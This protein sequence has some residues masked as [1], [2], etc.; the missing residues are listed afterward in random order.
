MPPNPSLNVERQRRLKDLAAKTSALTQRVE[1]ISKTFEGEKKRRSVCLDEVLETL[2]PFA[3]GRAFVANIVTGRAVKHTSHEYELSTL[4]P[5]TVGNLVEEHHS[6]GELHEIGSR[7]PEQCIVSTLLP[8]TVG[9]VIE[10]LHQLGK[11]SAFATSKAERSDVAVLL[12]VTVGTVIEEHHQLGRS[13][14]FATWKTEQSNVAMLLPVTVGTVIEEHHQLGKS[15]AYATSKTEQSTVA[16]LLPVTIGTV[17][18]EH[19]VL[20]EPREIGFD[21]VQQDDVSMLLP[22]TVCSVIEEHCRL[23]EPISLDRSEGSEALVLPPIAVGNLTQRNCPLFDEPSTVHIY[24]E[25]QTSVFPPFVQRTLIEHRLSPLRAEQVKIASEEC[26]ASMIF[27]VSCGIS[28]EKEGALR[29]SEHVEFGVQEWAFMSLPVSHGILIEETH[30]PLLRHAIKAV[31]EECEAVMVLPIINGCLVESLH[32]SH[33]SERVAMPDEEF[34]ALVMF[35]CADGHM[36]QATY[37]PLR[38]TP[39]DIASAEYEAM[40][41]L[42]VSDGRIIEE[43]HAPL[44]CEA[45]SLDF[46]ECEASIFLPTAFRYFSEHQESNLGILALDYPKAELERIGSPVDE[47]LS[48]SVVEG[49]EELAESSINMSDHCTI[50]YASINSDY[51]STP[52]SPSMCPSDADTELD[53]AYSDIEENE[54][55]VY[56][57]HEEYRIYKMYFEPKDPRMELMLFQPH[58]LVG[59][60]E[61]SEGEDEVE[62]ISDDD[63]VSRAGTRTDTDVDSEFERHLCEAQEVIDGAGGDDSICEDLEEAKSKLN[64]CDNQSRCDF[65]V[66]V[67][68]PVEALEVNISASIE[69]S[70]DSEAD[71]MLDSAVELDAIDDCCVA[72]KQTYAMVDTPCIQEMLT[73][74]ESCAALHVLLKSDDAGGPIVRQVREIIEETVDTTFPEIDAKGEMAT[75]QSV[76][77]SASAREVVPE[78]LEVPSKDSSDHH[79]ALELR[80]P[81]AVNLRSSSMDDSKAV[82]EPFLALSSEKVLAI[83]DRKGSAPLSIPM[84]GQQVIFW[85]RF[86]SIAFVVVQQVYLLSCLLSQFSL[87]TLFD[88]Q[89]S[90]HRWT[91][92]YPVYNVSAIPAQVIADMDLDLFANDENDLTKYIVYMGHLLVIAGLGRCV[93]ERTLKSSNHGS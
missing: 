25:Y 45:V 44:L 43:I 70:S 65:I 29:F 69:Q 16:A 9:T 39:V 4:V 35:P 42:P 23:N 73:S 84:S 91:G 90:M 55:V 28:V 19:H 82:L 15:S 22:V 54:D 88:K 3:N 5:D 33:H 57:S 8:V 81:S 18:E 46:D 2:F 52:S 62:D 60:D 53:I 12:P 56:V 75:D 10:E 47:T 40:I 59:I 21:Q 67:E 93:W 6:L 74:S 85:V 1:R 72:S 32:C 92:P 36:V 83:L 51:S 86:L 14:E 30:S 50:S 48:I 26:V 66:G 24:E 58:V 61:W 77:P 64:F 80:A 13:S 11:S 41:A 7:H 34:K 87:S 68:A 49:A 78:S 37:T 31:S 20:S 38:C 71:T 63:A 17:I 89:P 27:P 76:A 79:E